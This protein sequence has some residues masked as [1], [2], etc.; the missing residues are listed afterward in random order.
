MGIRGDRVKDKDRSAELVE[1]AGD[2]LVSRRAVELG[3]SERLHH[4]RHLAMTLGGTSSKIPSPTKHCLL[5][6]DVYRLV[7]LMG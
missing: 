1:Q 4:R 2:S 3:T 7:L 5:A 6:Y